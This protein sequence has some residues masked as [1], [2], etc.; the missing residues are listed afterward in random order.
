MKLQ[1]LSTLLLASAVS[2]AYAGDN[3]RSFYAGVFG[4]GGISDNN[5]ISQS[6]VAYKRDPANA[7]P[8]YLADYNYNADLLVNVIGYSA[9]KATG[10]GGI[11]F[12]Y[13]LPEIPMGGNWGI[14]PAAELEGFY[15]GSSMSSNLSNPAP[16][17]FTAPTGTIVGPNPTNHAP[18][19]SNSHTFTD[20]FNLDMGVLLANGVFSLK[21]PWS[22]KIFPYLGVGIGGAISSLSGANSTQTSNPLNPTAY[23][24]GI[25]HFNSDTNSTSSA[26]ASQAKAGI[27]AEIFGNLSAF[28]EYRFLH[29]TDTN[30]TFGSTEYGLEHAKTSPWS[31][32][33]GSMNYHSGVAGIQMSF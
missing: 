24:A 31:V 7:I 1:V 10:L 28:V 27:R 21:T 18:M 2:T 19:G 8:G 6:G 16:E 22:N 20:T 29:V 30:Y 15:L 12:G 4:G 9:E 13:E 32:G 11:H 25:N 23:E 14:R 17:I 5:N 3:S 26:F 33:M